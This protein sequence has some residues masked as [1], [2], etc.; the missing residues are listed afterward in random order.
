MDG[1]RFPCPAPAVVVPVGPVEVVGLTLNRPTDFATVL[2]LLDNDR[3]G[4]YRRPV[5]EKIFVIREDKLSP[6][7]AVVVS[8]LRVCCCCC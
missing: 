6:P 5:E 4:V 1:L 2:L 7:P 3:E 8:V